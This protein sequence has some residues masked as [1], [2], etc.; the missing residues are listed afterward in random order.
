M[1]TFIEYFDEITQQFS[2]NIPLAKRT[3][4]SSLVRSKI[5]RGIRPGWRTSCLFCLVRIAS[6]PR[7]HLSRDLH[8]HTRVSTGVLV[9]LALALLTPLFY[10]IPDAALAAVIMMAVVD[11]IDFSMVPKLWRV[12]SKERHSLPCRWRYS[13]LVNIRAAVQKFDI[14]EGRCFMRLGVAPPPT[15][16]INSQFSKCI[17]SVGLNVAILC[18]F[19]LYRNWSVTVVHRLCG[20]TTYGIRGWLI[21][22]VFERMEDESCCYTN[23]TCINTDGYGSLH[24]SWCQ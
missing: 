15:P 12:K 13:K 17:Q 23:I 10:F 8:P 24:V 4:F 9:L 6:N 21:C 20:V 16:E 14:C 5:S 2:A 7:V 1:N 11:M 22:I 19:L 18:V 3:N